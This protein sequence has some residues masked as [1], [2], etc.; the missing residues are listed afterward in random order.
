MPDE[1]FFKASTASTCAS[2]VRPPTIYHPRSVAGNE[3]K[4]KNKKQK[5]KSMAVVEVFRPIDALTNDRLRDRILRDVYGRSRP[6]D[7][8]LAAH[9]IQPLQ[10]SQSVV[11][12]L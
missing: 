1:T 5:R 2:R 11:R 7:H 9:V 3:K 6:V 4:N 12:H 10:R 8:L